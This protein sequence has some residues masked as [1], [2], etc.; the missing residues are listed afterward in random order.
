LDIPSL[1]PLQVAAKDRMQAEGIKLPIQ[2]LF[3]LVNAY[4]LLG[5]MEASLHVIHLQKLRICN[6]V[7]RFQMGK[8]LHDSKAA[9]LHW[10]ALIDL[11]SQHPMQF[12]HFSSHKLNATYWDWHEKINSFM[13]QNDHES[14]IR[15]FLQYAG[16]QGGGSFMLPRDSTKAPANHQTPSWLRLLRQ[17]CSNGTNLGELQCCRSQQL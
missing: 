9:L 6:K 10:C 8:A 13:Y 5:N 12:C 3:Y 14:H 1:W 2:G 15:E 4:C 16:M 17:R 7:A 11:E